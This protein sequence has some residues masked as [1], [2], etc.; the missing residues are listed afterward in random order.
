MAT[1][2]W[3]RLRGNDLGWGDYGDVLVGGLVWNLGRTGD[4]LLQLERTGPFVPPVTVPGND[5]VLVTT[6]VR[7]ELERSGLGAF[8]FR[9]VVLARV[10][11][12]PWPDWDL[13]A[14]DPARYP[15]GGE[16]ENYVLGRKD[17][18]R[19]RA[20][21]PEL[22]EVVLPVSEPGGAEPGDAPMVLRG[23]Y[24][25]VRDDAA[26]WLHERYGEWLEIGPWAPPDG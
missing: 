2:G 15:A 7:A 22:F 26:G 25:M 19:A 10:V 13:T 11:N 5:H 1:V 16:P 12:L 9:P 14:E 21:V 20:G 17:S 24:P 18:A 23:F 4:G 6:E 3:H 8:E